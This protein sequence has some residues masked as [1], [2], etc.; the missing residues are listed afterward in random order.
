[1]KEK[2]CSEET[3]NI[4]GRDLFIRAEKECARFSCARCAQARIKSELWWDRIILSMWKSYACIFVCQFRYHVRL[5]VRSPIHMNM[6]SSESFEHACVFLFE[7]DSLLLPLLLETRDDVDGMPAPANRQVRLI[8]PLQCSLP[9]DTFGPFR[10]TEW[11]EFLNT[12]N[13]YRFCWPVDGERA[14]GTDM[15]DNNADGL[16]CIRALSFDLLNWFQHIRSI[17]FASKTTRN[18]SING[19]R[20]E[21]RKQ[22]APAIARTRAICILNSHIC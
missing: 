15:C 16:N 22:N 12:F 1:M 11:K 19:K 8:Y 2:Y 9:F 6:T 18:A 14:G 3:A 5:R 4:V 17:L 20:M 13:T 7:R 10:S 21:E